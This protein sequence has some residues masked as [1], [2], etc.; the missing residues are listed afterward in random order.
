MNLET[1]LLLINCP[2]QKGLTAGITRVLYESDQN[3]LQIKEHVDEVSAHYYIRITFTGSIQPDDLLRKLKNA[4][5]AGT[6]I[7]LDPRQKKEIVVMATKEYHCLS[8]LLIRN[9][10]GE[11]N[12]N[13]KAVIA[14]R[15]ELGEITEKLGIPFHCI[16]HEAKS[17]EAFEEEM[18]EKVESYDPDYVVLA[19]YMRIISPEYIRRFKH[20]IINIHHSFLPAFI[21]ANPYKQAH[22]RGVKLIGATAHFVTED[23]DEGPIITQKIIQADHSFSASA[24]RKAGQEVERMVLAEALRQV[25]EDR[26]FVTGNKTVIFS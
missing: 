3:L 8:D 25:F 20:R 9:H 23:L 7:T 10:F 11:L 1:H 26:V 5:P 24:M 15:P 17:R 12:A 2:D 19:K 13:I 6:G 18:F 14:N 4:L 22:D 21:G 16:S